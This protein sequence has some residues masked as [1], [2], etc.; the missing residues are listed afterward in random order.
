M[1]P[2]NWPA[3]PRERVKLFILAAEQPQQQQK[4]VKQLPAATGT[5]LPAPARAAPSTVSPPIPGPEA[6]S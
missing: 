1:K 6:A 3:N 4:H 5:A 2:L